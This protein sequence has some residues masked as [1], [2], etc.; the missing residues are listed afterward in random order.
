MLLGIILFVVATRLKNAVCR[1]LLAGIGV[2]CVITGAGKAIL[3][4]GGWI[5][6]LIYAGMI[7]LYIYR[8]RVREKLRQMMSFQKKHDLAG[9]EE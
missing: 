5:P 8:Q 6:L 1:N 7:L 3:R 9:G 4:Y 2:V